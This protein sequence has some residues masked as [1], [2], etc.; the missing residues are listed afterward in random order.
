VPKYRHKVLYGKERSRVGAILRE[1][2]RYKGIEIVEAH[3]MPDHIHICISV[4]PKYSIAMIIGY[5][6]G[7]S[8]IRIH[9]EILGVKKN[10]TGKS[11][12]T[13]GYYVS[14]VGMDEKT[15][16]EYIRNQ[17]KLDQGEEGQLYL[18]GVD[19]K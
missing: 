13:R 19:I 3:A 12:W 8:V 17:E 18:E 7:K 4:P 9:R 2:C 15:V 14:T 10:F 6:K 16:R 5:L 11:F 1:L